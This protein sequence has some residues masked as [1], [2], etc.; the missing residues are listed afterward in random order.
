MARSYE[1]GGDLR[2]R[3]VIDAV[4]APVVAPEGERLYGFLAERYGFADDYVRQ[5]LN[6]L[7]NEGIIYVERDGLT[8]VGYD[9]HPAHLRRS[10]SDWT[11][12]EQLGA[13][14]EAADRHGVV[15]RARY[16][17]FPADGRPPS[18]LIVH[19][20]R[21]WE[22]AAALLGLRVTKAP[23]SDAQPAP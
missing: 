13:L 18:R 7:E 23:P 5:C 10:K 22:K 21:S 3:L 1:I 20:F 2:L 6:E 15:T 16:D 19:T 14:R 8:A 11:P 9:I 12:T 17:S 4:D